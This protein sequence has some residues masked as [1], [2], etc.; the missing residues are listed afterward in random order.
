M[1]VSVF[2]TGYVGLVQAAAL[3]DVGHRVLCVDIDEVKIKQLQ[4]AVP[5][6]QEP[7]L[8]A[9]IDDNLRE[10][11]LFFSTQASDAVIHGQLI[12]IAVGT[13]SDEDGSADLRHVL[14]VTREIAS[15]MQADCTL[16]IKSTVPVGTASQVEAV[17]RA[18]LD[19]LGKGRLAVR[20]VSNPEFLKE[21]SAVNDCVRPDRIIVGSD[22]ELAR[23]QLAELYAPF[24][25]SRDKLIFMDNRSAELTKYAAN[26]ML[27]TRISL[28]NE[29]A[30]LAERL[31][32]DIEAVRRGIGSDPRIGYHF[33]YPGCGF[34][35]SCFPKDLR[36]LLHTASASGQPLR[37]LQ[38]VQDV[39][40]T[41]RLVLFHKLQKLYPEGLAGKAIA[42]W[43]LAF[44]PNTDDMREA[45]SRYLMEA[46]WHAGATVRAF[47]PEAM[48]ECRRL[49]GYRDDLV[50][51]AT[52]DDT[53][54][55]TD[56]LVICTEWKAFRVVD[57]ELLA[58]QLRDRLIVDGRN[59]Y[60]PQ[61][62]AAAGLRYLGIGL[63]Y[64]DPQ[65]GAQ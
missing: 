5:P 39:N 46:L 35:G 12:F 50:L 29:L 57:F 14:G 61:Q 41:Q 45:P 34:G 59:L 6:I 56:A 51:C 10:G 63:P 11:R 40:E 44:K 17:A 36:A 31:G 1:D 20:V 28:M 52:R 4:R 42:L 48:S 21:G 47:D 55:D 23:A 53:L 30:N 18:E 13:P 32:A 64:V 60:S 2:G 65:G 8:S 7:G 19:R 38:S 43:G 9:M 16:V 62:A 25:R 33:I 24:C 15:H 58:H 3:A 49:Y 27:A 54:Q 22:D 37:L 26:A